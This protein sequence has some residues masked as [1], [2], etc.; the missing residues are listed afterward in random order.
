MCIEIIRN[1]LLISTKKLMLFE[2][3]YL[4]PPIV[5]NDLFLCFK[6]KF[7]THFVF[8]HICKLF[9]LNKTM[10]IHRAE[11]EEVQIVIEIES[12]NS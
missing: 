5:K 2:E 3:V 7:L 8:C 10:F 4:F 1:F 11:D 9:G 12:F 6:M